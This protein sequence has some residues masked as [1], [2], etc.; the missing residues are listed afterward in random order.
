MKKSMKVHKQSEE[1]TSNSTETSDGF[2]K[3]AKKEEEIKVK[4]ALDFDEVL[5][6]S[7]YSELYLVN[8]HTLHLKINKYECFGQQT[9]KDV[10]FSEDVGTLGSYN[11]EEIESIITKCVKNINPEADRS[12]NRWI[13]VK[14]PLGN[15]KKDLNDIIA[16][17]KIA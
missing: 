7:L 4:S 9:D 1:T 16:A 15:R 6:T 12:E 8:K 17:Y 2:V 14:A 5:I 11:I 13:D 10:I 3:I